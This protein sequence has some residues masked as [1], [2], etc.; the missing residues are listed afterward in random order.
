MKVLAVDYGTKRVG[1]AVGDE[2]LKVVSPKGVISSKEAVEKIK[3]IVKEGK[4]KKIV[5][6]YP[7]TPTGKEGPRAKLVKKF[8]QNLKREL[9]EVEIILWD[10][11]WTTDEAMRRLE[12]LPPRKKK[13]LRDV[14]SAMIIL[15]EYLSS[16]VK[17]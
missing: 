10:E 8:A 4:I 16:T 3:E 5:V 12:G 1:L 2:V 13:E 7:L 17:F 14:V 9:P 6:G 15:E 11:R